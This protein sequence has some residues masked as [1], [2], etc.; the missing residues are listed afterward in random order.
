[1]S[2]LEELLVMMRMW[3][4][5]AGNWVLPMEGLLGT[6]FRVSDLCL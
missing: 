3:E 6:R 2:P 5:R 1:M 4:F